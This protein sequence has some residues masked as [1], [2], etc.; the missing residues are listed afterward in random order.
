MNTLAQR[1]SAL[2]LGPREV[3]ALA[4]PLL[5]VLMLAMMILPLPP[6]MLDFFFTFNIALSLVV[7]M[8]AVYTVKPLDFA[9]FPIILLFTTVMRLSL[10][11][12]STRA[13]L[14]DGHTGPGAA[15]KVI[16]SFGHFVIGGNFAVGIVV[17]VILVVIN[18]VVITKGAGRIAEVAARFT[19][20][21]LPGKQMAIDADLN[22]GII[23]QAEAKRRRQEVGQEADF[24]GAMDGASKFVRGDAIA[25]IMILVVNVIGGLAIGIIWHNLSAA[26]AANNYVLL[27]IG[28]GLV[29]QIP[30]L[31]IS[32]AAALIVSRVGK[33]EDAG[34]Q[35]TN[36]LFGAPKS[37]GITAGVMGIIGLTPGMPHFVFLTFAALCGFGAWWLTQQKAAAAASPATQ[38]EVDRTAAPSNEATWDDLVPVD[39]LGLEV[40]YRLI[41]LV[42]KGQD[43][44]LLKK[45]KAIR[46][47][48]AQEVGF[49]PS[50]VHIRDNLELRPSAYQIL[51]KGVVVGT[52]EAV[53]G[54]LLAINPG[55]A[56]VQLQGTPAKDPAF[57]LPAVWIESAQREYAQMHGYTVVDAATVV[58]TH[59]S[60]VLTTQAAQLLG[61]A[62]V[63]QLVEHFAKFAPKL[64]EDVV[65][66]MVSIAVFQ[67][68]L[69]NL[70]EEGVHIRDLRSIVETVAEH[71]GQTQDPLE[72]TARVRVALGTAIVQQIY[73]P[74]QELSMIAFEPELERLLG[75]AFMAGPDAGLEPGLAETL[76]RATQSA[77]ERQEMQGLPPALLVPD[78]MRAPL[79]RLFKRAA[80]RLKVVAHSE[81]PENSS[82]RVSTVLGVQA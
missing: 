28:D 30:A 43:G 31:V 73:G 41:P 24:F 68:I 46:K 10:N 32:L 79:A 25:G 52:G 80:P 53:N 55:H 26:T 57:G 39:V 72:L 60:Q 42:D 34:S 3:K 40:G 20:D 62:E 18:F 50:S 11:V 76:L 56:Q 5:V 29:A 33:D 70:L 38:A 82:I 16:E 78:R 64:I 37:L 45:I 4:V 61:R 27:A 22:A 67:R 54:M 81:I 71:A 47:K 7:L 2:G 58:A 14:M 36:Q 69:Q 48:F 15:G 23:D 74:V 49:L 17:F 65:P 6:L 77:V 19:L 75:Q 1:L 63:S 66:K 44:E 8:V 35:M 21:A 12:A 59:L 51:L 13:V 9:A